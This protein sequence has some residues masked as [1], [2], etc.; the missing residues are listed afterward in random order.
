[1]QSR[2]FSNCT[3]LTQLD[4]PHSLLAIGGW[5]FDGCT[6]ISSINYNGTIEEWG[7]VYKGTAWASGVATTVVHCTNGDV[8]I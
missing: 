2:A 5:S 6:N 3:S 4:L 1:M 7:N 8:N